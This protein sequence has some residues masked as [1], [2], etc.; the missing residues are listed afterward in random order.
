MKKTVSVIAL[1]VAVIMLS[2]AAVPAFADGPADITEKFTDPG[3]RSLV[4]SA[5]GKARYERIFEDE[6]AELTRLIIENDGVFDFSGIEYLTGL[7]TLEVYKSSVESIAISGL[8][9]LREITVIECPYLSG[10]RLSD[11]P[12]LDHVFAESNAFLTSF[13]LDD[14]PKLCFVFVSGNQRLSSLE[15]RSLPLLYDLDCTDNS[16]RKLDLTDCP[17][18]EKLECSDNLFAGDYSIKVPEGKR[19]LTD[20]FVN[21]E[22]FIYGYIPGSLVLT[23]DTRNEKVKEMELC[24]I[25]TLD[26][27]VVRNSGRYAADVPIG[28]VSELSELL[29]ISFPFS[30]A[31]LFD[32]TYDGEGKLIPSKNGNRSIGITLMDVSDEEALEE[33]LWNPYIKY[34]ERSTG[35]RFDPWIE[36][37]FFLALWDV[38]DTHTTWY[39]DNVAYVYKRGIMVGTSKWEFSPDESLT[40]AM[41]VTIIHRLAGQPSIPGGA[42][43][44]DVPEGEWYSSAVRWATKA[45]IV[46]EVSET[47]FSPDG[48]IT[49]ADFATIVYRYGNRVGYVWEESEESAGPSDADSVPDYAKEAV[50]VL[51]RSGVL[52]GKENGV[53]DSSSPVTRA[54]AA[55]IFER[56]NRRFMTQGV[57]DFRDTGGAVRCTSGE[58][59]AGCVVYAAHS[60][61][62]VSDIVAAHGANFEG[63]SAH[64]S[65]VL[66]SYGDDFFETHTLVVAFIEESSGSFKIDYK[67]VWKLDDG[68]R[69]MIERSVPGGPV[70]DD[71][72]TWCVL[73]VI[74]KEDVPLSEIALDV[75]S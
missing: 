12:S 48:T 42:P 19:Y 4:Q 3:F 36:R 13:E 59:D 29:G 34:A 26:P 60:A 50:G 51:Y 1:V 53:F 54:E 27:E 10:V 38:P 7:E 72:A 16:L 37:D 65:D 2:A 17:A 33:L 66:A 22:S 40:R 18:I 43:F 44:S 73:C 64:L 32:V 21:K 74:P 49:R 68:Y 30:W 62:E 71:L 8:P 61:K 20:D 35:Y 55:A 5:L 69:V 11:L 47:S 58:E 46:N 67:G 52:V 39:Y 24:N 6:A 56:I 57:S 45:Q 9:S 14:L 25:Y 15:L 31:E 41:V 28:D 70:T 75:I 63:E 23:L